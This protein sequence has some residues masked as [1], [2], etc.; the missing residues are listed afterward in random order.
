M[1][2]VMLQHRSFAATMLHHHTFT[3]NVIAAP[4]GSTTMLH[5]WPHL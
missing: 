5:R 3:L 4:P 2:A 1:T